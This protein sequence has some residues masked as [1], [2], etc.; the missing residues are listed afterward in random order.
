M[1]RPGLVLHGLLTAL[2]LGTLGGV[3]DALTTPHAFLGREFLLV[4]VLAWLACALPTGLVVGVAG[5]ALV[6]TGPGWRS[7]AT[8][9]A[10]ITAGAAVAVPWF[11]VLVHVNVAILASDTGAEALLFDA[12]VTLLAVLLFLGLTVALARAFRARTVSARLLGPGAGPPALALLLVLLSLAGWRG[13]VGAVGP[14]LV[15]APAGAPDVVLI[16]ID[17]LRRDHLSGEGYDVLTTPAMDGLARAGARFPDFTSQSCY[18]KPAVASLLT[19]RYPSAH[20]VGHLR[21]VL[22]EEQLTL[23]EMFHA[24]GWRT[25]M[26]CSNTIV[27]PE[28]GFAQGAELFRTLESELVPKT[29]LGYALFRLT[30][31]GRDIGPARA[32]AWFLSAVERRVAGRRGAEVLGLSAGEILRDFREWRDSVGGDP[33]FAYLHVMEPHAP[34]VPPDPERSRFGHDGELVAEHPPTVGL[35]LPFSRADSVS[36]D[37]REGLVRAYDAEIAA[38]DRILGGFFAEIAASD[39]PTLIAVTSDHGEEFYEHG[40]WG[41]GQSLHREL[42]EVPLVL[43]GPG[44]PI[45]VEVLYPAQLVDIAPT[46][47]DLTGTP[48]PPGLAGRSLVPDLLAAASGTRVDPVGEGR[49]RLAEIVYGEA[50]WARALQ[51]G[52]WKLIVSHLGG[53]EAVRLYDLVEDPDELRDLTADEP[54]RAAAMRVRL[55]ELVAEAASGAGAASL[56]EF[57]PVTRERLE[58]LGYV[59]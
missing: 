46:L 22:A 39:R 42:L 32:L 38:L 54:E 10:A 55:D 53:E 27:G 26:F 7:P 57:D 47:L 19:S 4:S 58:A 48:V 40:G 8:I 44:V 23:T 49:E 15:A 35:F 30:E 28:F 29:K 59:E 17:T 14:P 1:S 12:G 34:Y 37:R 9:A 41:H 43:A 50:Y 52:R 20:R 56:A 25:A 51:S 5:A 2:L 24:A 36:G 16:L 21:T 6:R 13:G 45:G 18:T 3:A 33:V 31:S 11:L